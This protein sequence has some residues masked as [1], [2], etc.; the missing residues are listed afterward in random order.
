VGGAVAVGEQPIKGL[1]SP[2]AGA[3]M[4]VAE[5]L[6]NLLAAPIT[7]IRDVKMSGNWMWAAKCEGEGAR[8]VEAC[9]ALCKALAAVGCAI[10][11]GKDSLSMAAKVG[12]ELAPGTLVLSAYA[13]C[14]DVTKVLTPDFKGPKVGTD[15]TKIIYVRMGCSLKHNRLGGSAL[16]QALRQ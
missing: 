2:G 15:C 8:L 14:P 10:D 1:I 7:D 12:D 4:T 6:T 11:G 16:A 3:R 5:T 13:P 9:D